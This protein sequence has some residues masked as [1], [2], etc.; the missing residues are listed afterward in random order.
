MITAVVAEVGA[1]AVRT[2]ALLPGASSPHMMGGIQGGAGAG[3]AQCMLLL[4][5]LRSLFNLVVRFTQSFASFVHA[6]NCGVTGLRACGSTAYG[7]ACAYRFAVL[8]LSIRLL[9]L[10]LYWTRVGTPVGVGERLVNLQHPLAT[11]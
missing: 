1:L 4:Q 2:I 9:S 3:V 7:R 10:N 8:S 6:L 11:P 5:E